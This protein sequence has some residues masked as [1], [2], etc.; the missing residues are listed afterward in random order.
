MLFQK[1]RDGEKREGSYVGH[2]HPLPQFISRFLGRLLMM[3]TATYIKYLLFAKPLLSPSH[4]RS[5][6][7][8]QNLPPD[9]KK[10]A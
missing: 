10:K 7:T 2:M 3:T 6:L 4:S 9:P 1:E 5:H 8:S